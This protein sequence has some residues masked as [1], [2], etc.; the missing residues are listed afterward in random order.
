MPSMHRAVPTPL[1]FPYDNTAWIFYSYATDRLDINA[2][3]GGILKLFQAT[4]YPPAFFVRYLDVYLFSYA[5]FSIIKSTEAS[6][7]ELNSSK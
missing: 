4:E 2:K 3:I 6:S 5:I 7:K 1:Y